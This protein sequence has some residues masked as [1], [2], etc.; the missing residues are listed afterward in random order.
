MEIQTNSD[1][2]IEC[3]EPLTTHVDQVVSEALRR[4][5]HQITRVVVHL[6]QGTDSKSTA[7]DHRC[8]MEAHVKTHAPVGG[9]GHAARRHQAIHGAGEKLTRAVDRA[10][11]KSA[12]GAKGGSRIVDG[13]DV[14]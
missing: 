12:Q 1:N 7:G 9:T 5:S 13:L 14:A 6:G 4:F 2:T 10:L 11:G 8:M 3:H